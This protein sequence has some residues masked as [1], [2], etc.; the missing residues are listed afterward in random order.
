MYIS[1]VYINTHTYSIYLENIYMC[2]HVYIYIH[3]IYIINKYIYIYKTLFFSDQH[4]FIFG[5]D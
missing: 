4:F 2:L 3:I 5:C 1:D